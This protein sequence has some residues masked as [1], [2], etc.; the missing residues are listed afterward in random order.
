MTLQTL[1]N[2]ANEVK[3]VAEKAKTAKGELEYPRAAFDEAYGVIDDRIAA[4]NRTYAEGYE[5]FVKGVQEKIRAYEATLTELSTKTASRKEDIRK[6][7]EILEQIK[8][9]KT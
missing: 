6:A 8:N 9:T 4:A 2:L 3:A 5:A 7:R 1:E